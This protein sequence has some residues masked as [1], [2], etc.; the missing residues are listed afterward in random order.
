MSGVFD[1]HLSKVF[2]FLSQNPALPYT[3]EEIA[4]KTGI[5]EQELREEWDSFI[6]LDIVEEV[7]GKYRRK[8]S[9]VVNKILRI[10]RGDFG[11]IEDLSKRV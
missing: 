11:N 6:Y 2:E 9:K 3:I 5:D 8:D 1:E 7:D 4:E 10:K